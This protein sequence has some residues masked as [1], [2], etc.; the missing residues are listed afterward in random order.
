MLQQLFANPDIIKFSPEDLKRRGLSDEVIRQ[1]LVYRQHFIAE[2]IQTRKEQELLLQQQRQIHAQQT[3]N[4]LNSQ[5]ETPQL[6]PGN[7]PSPA[8][9]G[10]QIGLGANALHTSAPVQPPQLPSSV[11]LLPG[12]NVTQEQLIK[13]QE[14][15]RAA[16]G[17]FHNKRDYSSINLSHEQGILLEQSIQQ[18]QSLLKQVAQNLVSFVVLAPDDEGE[19]NRIAQT[20]VALSD[21]GQILQKPPPEKRFILNL[22]DLNNYRN[23]LTTFLMRVKGLQGHAI[24]LQSQQNS[25]PAPSG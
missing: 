13:A 15:V 5:R 21:Q 2:Q 6:A 11:P 23:H 9:G 25:G 17:L 19:L 7:Q 16:I 4:L 12:L 14:K 10:P 18:T 3:A 22:G 20:V 8:L 24:A 1:V